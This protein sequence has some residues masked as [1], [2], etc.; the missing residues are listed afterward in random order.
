[1][2]AWLYCAPAGWAGPQIVRV[3][4][5]NV[6]NY[7]EVATSTRHAKSAASKAAVCEGILALHPDVLALEE[8]GSTNALIDLEAQ[9]KAG[10]LDMPA[11]SYQ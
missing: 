5:F 8:I 10:G 4:T 1:M 7:I 3:A 2:A 6:E 9:L 11:R